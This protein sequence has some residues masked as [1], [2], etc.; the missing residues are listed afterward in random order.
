MRDGLLSTLK[1]WPGY[2]QTKIESVKPIEPPLLESDAFAVE[3]T[4][5]VKATL[6]TAGLTKS[7]EFPRRRRSRDPTPHF[8]VKSREDLES[9][10]EGNPMLGHLLPCY[11]QP[12]KMRLW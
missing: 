9:E 11:C 6:D 8:P 4:A 12:G 3:V 10:L 1:A 7:I 5:I 2:H